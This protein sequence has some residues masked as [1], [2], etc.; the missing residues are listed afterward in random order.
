[1]GAIGTWNMAYNYPTCFSAVVPVCGYENYS[2]PTSFNSQ[3]WAFYG[4]DSGDGTRTW[5]TYLI[6]NVNKVAPGK[7]K[8]TYT[9]TYHSASDDYAYK[10]MDAINWMIDQKN[11][12]LYQFN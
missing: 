4:T 1:M 11:S 7:G 3:V 9:Y 2:V 8:K 6:N 12:N 5:A 10:T